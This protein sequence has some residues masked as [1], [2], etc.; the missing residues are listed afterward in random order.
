M[1]LLLD[2]DA[3]QPNVNN[4]TI[5]AHIF[6]DG[7]LGLEQFYGAVLITLNFQW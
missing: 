2:T 3:L 5:P 1:W 6:I 4:E 7:Y